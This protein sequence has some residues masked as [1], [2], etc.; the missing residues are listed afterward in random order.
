MKISITGRHLEVSEAARAQI[1]KKVRR[2]DRLLGD[3][4]VSAQCALWE[5]RGA[6][7]FEI[8]IHARADHMLHALARSPRIP[9]AVTLAV[10]KV[11]QQAQKLADRWKTRRRV[12]AATR[13][14]T[15]ARQSRQRARATEP[16]A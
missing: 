12:P 13:P 1:E 15:A 6:Y 16:E 9:T 5:Q 14:T 8:T 11:S 7:V 10:A 4:A 3:S 2:I